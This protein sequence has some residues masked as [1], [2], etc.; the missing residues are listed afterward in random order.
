M[1]F[2]SM[3]DPARF[4]LQREKSLAAIRDRMFVIALSGDRVVPPAGVIE[5]LGN[6]CH[7]EVLDFPFDYTHEKPFPVYDNH[8][9]AEVDAGFEKVFI[10][11]CRFLE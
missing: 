10:P 3:L 1:A 5:T 4:R 2:R 9:S 6:H 8:K 11:A 7:V